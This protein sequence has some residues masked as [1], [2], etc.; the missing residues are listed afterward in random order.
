M[1][2]VLFEILKAVV[3][4]AIIL[5]GRYVIPFIKLQV[6]KTRYAWLINWVELAVRS[7]EQTILGDKSGPEKKAIVTK[8]IKEQLEA[9]RISISD[10]QLDI[11]I[12][13]AVYIMNGERL[14]TIQ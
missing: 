3:I 11:L 7:A 4:L 8:F 13:S 1:N 5:L 10:D 12:E 14:G 2:E 9:K 6:E